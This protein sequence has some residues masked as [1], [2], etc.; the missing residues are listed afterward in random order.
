MFVKNKKIFLFIFFLLPSF[1]L[2]QSPQENEIFFVEKQFDLLQRERIAAKLIKVSQKAYFFVDLDFLANLSHF[3]KEELEKKI[4]A[5]S[6]EFD[7]FIYPRLTSFFGSEMKPGIDQDERIFVL[8]EKMPS[9]MSGYFREKDEFYRFQVFDSNQKEILYL[10]TENLDLDFLKSRLSHE[11]FHLIS[12]NQK[13]RA[14]G[15]SDEIWLE[16]L[17]AELAPVFLGYQ[18][19]FEERMKNFLS[20]PQVS[21]IDWN[22]SLANYGMVFLFGLYLT[23][24]YGFDII[25]HTLK[26]KKTDLDALDDFFISRGFSERTSDLFHNFLI[27]LFLNDCSQDLRFCFKNEKLKKFKIL[28]QDIFL[29]QNQETVLSLFNQINSFSGSWQRI[30]GGNDLKVD[31]QGRG[32]LSF[33]LSYLLCKDNK[34]CQVKKISLGNEKK[35][36]MFFPNFGKENLFL[37]IITSLT[38]KTL[39]R[40]DFSLMISS[41]K[42]NFSFPQTPSSPQAP[43]LS[44]ISCQRISQNLFLGKRGSEVSCLQEFLKAQGQEIYPEG[45]VTGYF[46]PLTKRAV[47]KFQEKYEQEILKPWGLTKGTGF[48]GQTTRLKIEQLLKSF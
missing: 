44:K 16:E 41:S 22:Q 1:L 28:P 30:F 7:N 15:L 36:Q 23:E 25:S 21:L 40:G 34:N 9:Q 32:D 24:N 33:N 18:N 29:P 4:D 35:N 45:L 6:L 39:K 13:K 47:I 12:F 11:F 10:N 19:S 26:T 46:G 37:V 20:Y 8:F 48:V 17:R 2:G 14:F 31:F 27:A 43:S 5:L 3:Q 42:N 38:E